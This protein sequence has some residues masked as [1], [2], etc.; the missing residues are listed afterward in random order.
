MARIRTQHIYR[1]DVTAD[2]SRQISRCDVTPCYSE[3]KDVITSKGFDKF[4]Y[5]SNVYYQKSYQYPERSGGQYFSFIF[6]YQLH[7]INFFFLLVTSIIVT[8]ITRLIQIGQ[9]LQTSKRGH[10]AE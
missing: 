2:L 3:T 4:K 5:F 1:G 6:I 7:E 8:F 10:I 9:P